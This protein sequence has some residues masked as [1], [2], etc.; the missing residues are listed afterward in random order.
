MLAIKRLA[1]VAP[2]VNPLHASKEAGKQGIHL[3]LETQGRPHQ[4]S[5]T[6]VSVA[7]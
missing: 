7:P 2:E 6:G 5:N 1:G 4:K 3:G